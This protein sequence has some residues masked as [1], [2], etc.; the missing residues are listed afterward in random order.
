MASGVNLSLPRLLG[1]DDE[2][3]ASFVPRLVGATGT[4]YSLITAY[5]FSIVKIIPM[6]THLILDAAK[7]AFYASSP[8]LFGFAR[9]GTRY[10]LPH[11]IL[12]TADVLVAITT[13]ADR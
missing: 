13:K 11:V 10:W 2:S 3:W 6:P 9:N 5:E 1:L 8:W 12:G 4:G 7:G